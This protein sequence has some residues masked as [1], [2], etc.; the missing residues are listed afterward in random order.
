MTSNKRRILWLRI[1]WLVAFLTSIPVT[2]KAAMALHF[3]WVPIRTEVDGTPQRAPL[4][5]VRV[6]THHAITVVAKAMRFTSSS[7][8][9][10]PSVI[11]DLRNHLWT[12]ADAR[13]AAAYYFCKNQ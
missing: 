4:F 3:E 13:K 9:S 1:N 5:R 8:R 6:E 2:R 11:T 7:T 10:R 12:A